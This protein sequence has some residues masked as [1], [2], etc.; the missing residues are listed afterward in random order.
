MGKLCQKTGGHMQINSAVVLNSRQTGTTRVWVEEKTVSSLLSQQTE[1]SACVGAAAAAVVVLMLV[2]VAVL[3]MKLSFCESRED[4]RFVFRAALL[5]R[6]SL[7]CLFNSVIC[8][9][10]GGSCCG[11]IS[12]GTPDWYYNSDDDGDAYQ[13][14]LPWSLLCIFLPE[15][16]VSGAADERCNDIKFI[17]RE[18]LT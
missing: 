6:I 3:L 13:C 8:E 15:L 7:Q 4:L 9:L 16:R 2:V 17:D 5:A 18:Q 10:D 1:A 12:S 14:L 11:P